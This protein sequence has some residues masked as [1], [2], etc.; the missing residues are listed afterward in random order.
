MTDSLSDSEKLEALVKVIKGFIDL[1]YVDNKRLNYE[2]QKYVAKRF[3]ELLED[4]S[5]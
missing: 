4:L 5:L 1:I 3:K 2:Q